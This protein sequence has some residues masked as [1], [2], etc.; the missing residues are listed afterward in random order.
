MENKKNKQVIAK[1]LAWIGL[2]VI[3][4]FIV[5]ILYALIVANGKLALAMI[6]S[7]IFVSILYWIGIAIYKKL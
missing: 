1:V 5:T 4:I 2:I 7:L 3:A 6:I